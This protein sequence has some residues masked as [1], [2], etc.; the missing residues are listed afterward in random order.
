MGVGEPGGAAALV[1]V[2]SNGEGWARL[3]Q[4]KL[5]EVCGFQMM[6]KAEQTGLMVGW[7]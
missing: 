4:W 1:G 3:G 6:R 5:G 7:M 2:G